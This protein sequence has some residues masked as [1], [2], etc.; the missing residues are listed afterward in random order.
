MKKIKL[1]I[2]IIF[3]IAIW[4]EEN[5]VV[6][7]NDKALIL[8][9]NK[10]KGS[11]VICNDDSILNTEA[12][13]LVHRSYGNALSLDKGSTC[14]IYNMSLKQE[15]D[16]EAYIT[17]V[18]ILTG[19]EQIIDKFHHQD[20]VQYTVPEDGVFCIYLISKNLTYDLTEQVTVSRIC[21]N[22]S[23]GIT[24]CIG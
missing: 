17:I 5:T 3:C 13:D 20:Y 10:D 12:N 4:N 23:D 19:K 22:E 9:T 15:P 16:D 8:S 2:L 11:E 21:E 18:N 24:N 1:F 14:Y 6:S 7:T